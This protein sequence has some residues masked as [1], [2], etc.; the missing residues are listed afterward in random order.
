MEAILGYLIALMLSM[1]SFAGFVTWAKAGVTNV[2]T[3]A[4]A[5][6][7]LVFD[8][9]ALQFVQDEAATLVA[10][11]TPSVPVN[12]TPA[13]LINGGY[14]P[15]GF[16]ATNVFGQTWL[17]QVLQP[18][19][20]NLQALV[21][22]QGGRAITDTR[23]LVQIAAQAGA[24]GG[25]VPYAGQNGDPTMVANRAYGAYGAWQVPLANYTNPGSGRLASLLA[26][27]GVQANNGYLYRAQVPGHPELNR[28]QTSIDM[29]GNDVNNA[30]RVT[31]TTALTSQGDTYLTSTGAPGTAC[32]V[33]TSTRR[34][35]SG[36]GHVICSGGIWQAVGTAVANIFEGLGCGNNGQI[37][38]SATNVGYV[39]KGNR[40][41]TLNNA[42]G[43]MNVT[44]KFENVTDGMTFP[45]DNCPGGTAWAMYTPKQEM[46]NITG[47][48]IPPIQGT[49][50]SMNDNG[51]FWYAQASAIS[52]AAWYSGNDTGALGGQLV[53][54]VTTGCTF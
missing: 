6:Q 2:Q 45:K 21:T 17:L 41:I 49:F 13:M 5:S 23:Q 18:T 32:A 7:M 48:V 12:I 46:V 9:A 37:A 40:Y 30:G 51:T 34:S 22:S 50:F 4:A 3:A 27:T 29:A 11:A 36:T 33:D 15:A 42:L 1:L 28:M 47:N 26:F 39:C 10:Q 44:R 24:Q 19:P 53:G 35:T 38:T 52:P 31:A 43:N 14:L 20:N 25:F 8:K 16:S 54:T